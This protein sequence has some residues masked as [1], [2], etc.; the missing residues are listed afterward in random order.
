[1]MGGGRGSYAALDGNPETILALAFA[2]CHSIRGGFVEPVVMEGEV[3]F[4]CSSGDCQPVEP[5]GQ[6]STTANVRSGRRRRR[7]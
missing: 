4:G 1:M 2:R 7:E 5:R 6:A 3:T